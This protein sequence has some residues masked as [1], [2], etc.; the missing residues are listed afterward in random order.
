M[1]CDETAA[2]PTPPC[3]CRPGT[4][5]AVPRGS[6][7]KNVLCKGIVEDAPATSDHGGALAGQV[8]SA[9]ETRGA[10]LVQ[11]F[12]SKLARLNFFSRNRVEPIK[13]IIPS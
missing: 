13:Q 10:K 4:E 11:A 2:G 9:K 6:S 1:A 12:H 3:I 8:I 5:E 7:T